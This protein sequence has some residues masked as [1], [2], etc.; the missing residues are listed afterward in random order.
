MEYWD[1]VKKTKEVGPG[2]LYDLIKNG[3]PLP[4]NFES[5]NQ[6]EERLAAESRRS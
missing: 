3:D 4:Q 6:R 2:F 1:S 5:K